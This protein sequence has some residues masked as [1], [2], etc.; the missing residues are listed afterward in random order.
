MNKLISML[1]NNIPPQKQNP[2]ISLINDQRIPVR[3]R[4]KIDKLHKKVIDLQLTCLWNDDIVCRLALA[5]IDLDD[6]IQDIQKY[7]KS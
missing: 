4:K 2:I 6:A 7:I 5:E 3:H 1:K